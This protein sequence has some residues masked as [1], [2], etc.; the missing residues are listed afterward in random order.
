MASSTTYLIRASQGGGHWLKLNAC[1]AD[2]YRKALQ[3]LGFIAS[4]H[5]SKTSMWKELL[6][7]PR[8]D[9]LRALGKRELT[10]AER[11]AAI[12]RL[13]VAGQL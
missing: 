3:A 7:L 8:E 5:M 4:S 13:R 9:V 12:E 6:K 11:D 2:A 1:S 10:D